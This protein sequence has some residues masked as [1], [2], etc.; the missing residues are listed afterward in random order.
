MLSIS[1]SLLSQNIHSFEHRE[2]SEGLNMVPP[3][4]TFT[5]FKWVNCRSLLILSYPVLVIRIK[6]ELQWREQHE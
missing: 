4:E 1:R 6:I 3:M 5:R 2:L